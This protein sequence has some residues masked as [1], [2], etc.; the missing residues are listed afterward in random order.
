MSLFHFAVRRLGF[1]CH[2]A[3]LPQA[4]D[5]LLYLSNKIMD[6]DR[7]DRVEAFKAAVGAWDGVSSR[8]HP[9]GGTE[10]HLERGEVGHV[11]SNGLV[12]IPFTRKVKAEVIAAGRATEH[13]VLPD[14]GW[15]SVMLDEDADVENAVDLMRMSYDRYRD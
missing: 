15:V 1:L 6:K 13:H 3:Y 12:D 14:S 7:N 11:H 9:Y 2:V 5:R 8:P 4:F 10:F